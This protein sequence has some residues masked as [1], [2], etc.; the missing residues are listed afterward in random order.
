VNGLIALN[1]LSP[2]DL[3]DTFG[4]AGLLLVI[5]VESGLLPVPLPGDSLLFIAGFFCSTKAGGNDPHLNLA[6]VVF[7]AFAAAVI[8]AQ[9]GYW[10]GRTFGT[11]LFKPD[12]RVFK[13]KYL[14]QAHEFFE[15]RGAGAVVLARFIPFVRTIVPILAGTSRMKQH[16]FLIANIIGA[17]VWAGGVTMLGYVLGKQIGA[18]NIDHYLLPIVFVII[19]L[20]LIPPLLEYRKHRKQQASG[21]S[22]TSTGD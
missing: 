17:A 19:V 9:L 4:T 12:A 6:V 3:I 11:R 7:G 21:A 5:L 15:R 10:I 8:G 16:A 20:S 13:T 2:R 22:T 1:W 14:E 18:D